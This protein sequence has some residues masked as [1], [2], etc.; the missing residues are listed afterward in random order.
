SYS[1]NYAMAFWFFTEDST[2][3][4][5][6]VHLVWEKHLQVTVFHNNLWYAVCFPQGYYTDKISNED[7]NNKFDTALNGWKEEIKE[8]SGEWMWIICSVSNFNQTY[9]INESPKT[10]FEL[11]ALYEDGS[12][13][14]F[15]L[16]P[17]RYFMS[18]VGWKSKLKLE[19][20]KSTRKIYFRSIQLFQDYIPYEYLI[21]Y[22]DLSKLVAN[23][24]PSLVFV[25]NFANIKNGNNPTTK[26]L[27]YSTYNPL[28][29]TYSVNLIG[30]AKE[31]SANF[32]FLPLCDPTDNQGYS[33]KTKKCGPINCDKNGLSAYNCYEGGK[34]LNC[35]FQYFVNV[36]GDDTNCSNGCIKEILRAP[37]TSSVHGICTL[38]CP[39]GSNCPKNDLG[40]Y[41]TGYKCPSRDRVNYYC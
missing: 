21:R 34:P 27:T 25:C 3:L 14:A 10:Q 24:M 23:Y 16:Y 31:L 5:N 41:K 22:M 35:Q 28:I 2:T 26:I 38:N 36:I 18:E 1:G 4:T 8:K 30:E 7:I 17:L 11:E 12:L 39:V 20:I 6:G 29:V 13:K 15:S 19:N 33:E 32:V 9:F 40:N 37:G